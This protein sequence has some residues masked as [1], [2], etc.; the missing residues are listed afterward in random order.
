M[1]CGTNVSPSATK[2]ADGALRV[3]GASVSRSWVVIATDDIGPGGHDMT[4][5]PPQ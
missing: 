1:G 5:P 4:S 2:K 3:G